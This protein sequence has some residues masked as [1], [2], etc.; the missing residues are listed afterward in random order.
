MAEQI[1]TQP[2][3]ILKGNESAIPSAAD[4]NKIY[5]AIDTGDILIYNGTKMQSLSAKN[6]N[7][8]LS[9]LAAHEDKVASATDLGHIKIG[10][11][12][13]G[14]NYAVQLD[15]NNKAYVY[16]PWSDTNTHYTTHLY[17]GTGTAANATTTNG[18]T[19]ITVTDDAT[20]RNSITIQGSGATTVTSDANGVITI[21]SN[22]TTYSNA[23]TSAAGLMSAEDKLKLN[24]LSDTNTTYTFTG[25]TNKFTVTPSDGTAFDVT[26]TPSIASNVT[27]SGTWT[28][29]Q[30]AVLDTTTGKI[31]ASGYTIASSVPSN[32]KFTD[33]TYSTFTAATASADGTSGLVPAPLKDNQ[34]SFL[35]GDGKWASVP[36][37][38]VTSVG[39]TMPT[40]FSVTSS[41]ITASGTLIVSFAS[42]YSLPTITKQSNWDTAYGWGNHADAGYT[43]NTGTVTSVGTGTGLTGGPI[44]GSGTI[45]VNLNNETSLGTIG[46]TSK[47]YA[48]GVDSNGKLAVAVPWSD[49]NTTYSAGTGLSLSGTTFSVTGVTNV[50]GNTLLKSWAGATSALPSSRDT[51][52]IYYVTA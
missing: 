10:Y 40:G 24:G 27:Y 20:V 23:T 50:N 39:L 8:V 37:G 43:K 4:N 18:N 2:I 3:I 35:R 38:T 14:K 28:S 48:V 19:K 36:A 31:K 29:G 5:I 26:V 34:A 49:T 22:N 1:T 44:S 11:T 33:T 9:L 47:L 21:N 52:T 45:K 6:M 51:S 46:T 32:A 16:V 7:A 25:G 30:V 13:S 41:P 17:A 15:G 12:T 42:G